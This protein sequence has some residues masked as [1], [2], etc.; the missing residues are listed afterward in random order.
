MTFSALLPSAL[1]FFIIMKVADAI[2]FMLKLAIA[3]SSKG[4][5]RRITANPLL[6]ARGFYQR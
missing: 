1:M 6:A 2:V 5:V 4:K 3:S